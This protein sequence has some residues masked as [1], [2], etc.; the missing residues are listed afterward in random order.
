MRSAIA[1]GEPSS[2]ATVAVFTPLLMMISQLCWAGHDGLA[3]NGY[4][5]Y[6]L[7]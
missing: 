3:E 6:V 2:F 5:R 1:V 4:E 7:A